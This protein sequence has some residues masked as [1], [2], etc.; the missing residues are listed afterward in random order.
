M[1]IGNAAGSAEPRAGAKQFD[2][3]LAEQ[4]AALRDRLEQLRAQQA[5]GISPGGG[6]LAPSFG[7]APSAATASQQA[8]Q[9]NQAFANAAPSNVPVS[10][11]RV[12]DDMGYRINQGKMI[13][14]V[15]ESAIQS[16]LPGLVRAVVTED[17]YS[18]DG[19]RVLIV[20]GSRLVGEYAS[21]LVRGQSRVFVI[22]NRVIQ[23][24]GTDIQIGSRGTDPLGRAGL[25]G[26]IDRHFVQR[27]GAAFLLSL[28]GSGVVLAQENSTVVLNTSESFQDT[29]ESALEQSANIPPTVHID[30][31]TPIQVFVARDLLFSRAW[32]AKR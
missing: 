6:A 2:S 30:Q 28:I 14:A 26:E 32:A 7:A 1:L 23:P 25:T 17:V 18:A 10:Q 22:W 16:D 27:F 20:R 21:G 8:A 11:A 13:R 31:G 19:E 4:A 9:T 24:D 5:A 3:P 15:L 29:A 12:L